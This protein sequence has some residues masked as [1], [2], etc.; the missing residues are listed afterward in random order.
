MKDQLISA[1]VCDAKQKQYLG[2]RPV[3]S[4]F[5]HNLNGIYINLI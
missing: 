1:V 2:N 3:M 5:I 4:I